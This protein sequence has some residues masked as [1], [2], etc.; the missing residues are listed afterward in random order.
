MF[1]LCFGCWTVATS[2]DKV[3]RK[4]N[5]NFVGIKTRYQ[6]AVV[7]GIFRFTSDIDRQLSVDSTI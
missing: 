4:N 7:C 1:W 2:R 5:A 6:Q 3:D